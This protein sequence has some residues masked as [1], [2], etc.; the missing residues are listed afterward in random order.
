MAKKKARRR[1]YGRKSPTLPEMD[2]KLEEEFFLLLKQHNFPLPTTQHIFHHTR[3]WRLDFSWI[4]QRICVEIQGYGAG[5]TSYKGMHEDYVKHNEAI[6]MGWKLYYFMSSDI[7]EP[8]NM[9][10][11]LGKQLNVTPNT[12]AAPRWESHIEA[13]R[14]RLHSRVNH[15]PR[16]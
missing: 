7:A 10:Q 13:G 2:S 4:P 9:L 1:K 3:L 5:H 15:P 14:R 12:V 11:F 8:E 6:A 16:S